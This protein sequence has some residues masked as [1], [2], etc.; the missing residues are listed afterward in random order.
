M[1][2]IF[3]IL[4]LLLMLTLP[5]SAQTPAEILARRDR[6]GDPPVTAPLAEAFRKLPPVTIPSWKPLEATWTWA[7]GKPEE[8]LNVPLSRLPEKREPITLP[9]RTLHPDTPYWY[10]TE[11]S[12]GGPLVLSVS[13]DDGAQVFANDERVP[14]EDGSYFPI[15]PDNNGK[16]RL[17]IRVLNKAVY[18]GLNGVRRVDAA[19]YMRW[20]TGSDRRERL[21][22]LVNKVRSVEAPNPVE[23]SA[24]IAAVQEAATG[25]TT[26]TALKAAEQKLAARPMTLIGPYLQDP[27]SDRMTIVWETDAPCQP[28]LEWIEGA[29]GGSTFHKAPITTKDGTLHIARLTGLKPG[30]AYRYRLKNAG[31]VQGDPT[32]GRLFRFQSLPVDK[33]FTFTAWADSQNSWQVFAQNIVAMQSTAPDA[34]FTVGVGDLVEDGNR[35]GPWRDLLAT[36][37]PL[38]CEVPAML[39]GGNHD[40]DGRFEDLRSPF[41]ER[42]CIVQ[43]RPQHFAWTSGNARFV[44]LDPNEYFPTAIPEGSIEHQ[45]LMKE[46]NSPE[47][48]AARWHFIFIHQPPYSQGWV[49][50]H[51][52]DTIRNL[53]EPLIEKHGIDFVV[54]G[55]SHDYER[56]TKTYGKQTCHFLI[57]GGAGGGL[58]GEEMSEFP[59]MDVVIRRHHFGKFRVEADRVLFEAVATDTR[60]LDRLEAKK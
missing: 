29:E 44:A 9:Q 25:S 33:G 18:G 10:V 56:L 16:V 17:V 11:L 53:L 54:S 57:V 7:L 46:V 26:D 59:K 15:R 40:Y 51:G 55:H 38:A 27:A 34:V 8:G 6:F 43:P 49:D 13:A 39:V 50:Y 30:T 14:A 2:R 12:P 20:R 32:A 45:W 41:F 24:V 52:D 4:I 19:D 3:A 5:S 31:A 48:K 47:W 23:M 42:Y 1:N 58:E 60:V 21:I 28:T 22:A 36:L 35:I 37:T